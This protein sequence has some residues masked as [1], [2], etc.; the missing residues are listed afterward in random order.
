[1]EPLLREALRNVDGV[2]AAAIFGS[3]AAGQAEPGSDVDLLVIGEVDRDGLLDSVR[4][5]ER[6]THREIDVTAYRRDEFERRREEGSGF[7]RTVLAGPLTPLIGEV[8]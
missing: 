8:R 4:E 7:I 1:M 2:E 3:W 6:L 5:M